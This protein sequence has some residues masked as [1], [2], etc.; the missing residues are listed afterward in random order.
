MDH[1][2]AELVDTW[3]PRYVRRGE[4]AVAV[5]EKLR[6]EAATARLHHPAL[7]T[8]IERCGG[9]LGV[10]VRVVDD[11]EL[12]GDR[13]QVALDLG[14]VLQAVRR[15]VG[16]EA[17]AV[18]DEVRVA[19]RAVPALRVPDA[20]DVAVGLEHDVG[21]L[22]VAQV[23]GRA[24]AGDPRADDDGGRIDGFHREPPLVIA[25]VSH[26]TK[27]MSRTPAARTHSGGSTA[28]NT[29]GSGL[30]NR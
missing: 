29:S 26:G 20:A 6:R 16:L 7:R 21:D 25:V 18:L 14:A 28:R 8:A 30:P 2:A 9:D 23:V 24:Y 5:D 19:A 10:E 3:E 11:R 1:L 15:E 12:L 13:A 22:A 17:E 4:V 27:V